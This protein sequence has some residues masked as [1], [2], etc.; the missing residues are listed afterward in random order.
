MV[1]TID[2]ERMVTRGDDNYGVVFCG[3]TNQ[4][5]LNSLRVLVGLLVLLARARS[6]YVASTCSYV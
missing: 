6:S 2:P 4:L 1:S 5:S 3:G